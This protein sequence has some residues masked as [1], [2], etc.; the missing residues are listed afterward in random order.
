METSSQ[1]RGMP[2]L[3]SSEPSGMPLSNSLVVWL[4]KNSTKAL[5]TISQSA[6]CVFNDSYIL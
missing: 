5:Q 4:A 2:L 3:A 1:M 6:S